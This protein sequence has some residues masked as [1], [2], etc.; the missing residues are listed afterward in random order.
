MAVKLRKPIVGKLVYRA[1]LP[2][3]PG[4]VIEDLG[5]VKLAGHRMTTH[6]CRW[7]DIKGAVHTSR[8]RLLNDFQMLIDEHASKANKFKKLA[9][10]LTSL[11]RANN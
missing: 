4:I 9:R 3:T 10:E 2:N 6:W 7:R 5:M 8:V 1:F 11:K